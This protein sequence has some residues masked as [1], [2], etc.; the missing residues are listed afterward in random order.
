L[1][2]YDNVFSVFLKIK[3]YGNH[4]YIHLSPKQKLIFFLKKTD[5][6]SDNFYCFFENL[7]QKYTKTK[8][9]TITNISV[10]IQAKSKRRVV[11]I[12]VVSNF[13]LISPKKSMRASIQKLNATRTEIESEEPFPV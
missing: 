8:Y 2:K 11:S 4:H 9:L 6:V 7:I 10:S 13:K 3:K 1:R 5:L 12:L